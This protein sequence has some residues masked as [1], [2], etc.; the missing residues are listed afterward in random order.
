MDFSSEVIPYFSR[1]H[2][3]EH[4]MC[5]LYNSTI[6]CGKYMLSNILSFLTI[7]ECGCV[8]RV[9]SYTYSVVRIKF[10]NEQY[11]Y[12]RYIMHRCRKESI[13][14]R[15]YTLK[16]S[17]LLIIRNPFNDVIIHIL[18]VLYIEYGKWRDSIAPKI[19]HNSYIPVVYETTIN[20]GLIYNKNFQLYLIH[21]CPFINSIS[22]NAD[23]C[24]S[25]Y[26]IYKEHVYR[27]FTL[28]TVAPIAVDLKD[29]Y[30]LSKSQY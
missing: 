5:E 19:G 13:V 2:S 17:M 25:I 18:T 27:F 22:Y 14:N 16:H 30:I 28:I 29:Q 4:R 10:T 9:C 20:T 26:G 1:F 12:T 21:A 24:Y 8:M 7:A 11:R 15:L 23:G 6:F 3:E